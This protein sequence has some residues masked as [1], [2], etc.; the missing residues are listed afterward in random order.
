MA[1]DTFHFTVDTWNIV[2]QTVTV[3]QNMLLTETNVGDS[4]WHTNSP[5]PGNLQCCKSNNRWTTKSVLIY[6]RMNQQDLGLTIC[7]I[8]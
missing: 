4:R 5:L 2:K 1:T 8:K 7:N 3:E 6:K